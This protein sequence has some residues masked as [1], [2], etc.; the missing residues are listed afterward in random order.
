MAFIDVSRHLLVRPIAAARPRD[1]A[2]ADASAREHTRAGVAL[3]VAW[4][5]LAVV[6]GAYAIAEQSVGAVVL[7]LV[8]LAILRLAW[9][10]S[11]PEDDPASVT[12]ERMI[13]LLP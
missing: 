4:A 13:R 10:G 6:F 12:V 7:M 8:V 1:D 11:W 5:G 2:D 9:T 3:A